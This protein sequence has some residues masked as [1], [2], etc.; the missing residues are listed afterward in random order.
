MKNKY[1]GE[2]EKSAHIVIYGAG[3]IGRKV[4]G[5][6]EKMNMQNKVVCFAVSDQQDAPD[7]IN[8]IMV[9]SIDVAARE[10]GDALFLLSVSERFMYELEQRVIHEKIDYYFDGKKIYQKNCQSDQEQKH[11][12]IDVNELFMQQYRNGRYNRMDIVVRYLAIENYHGIND[13]GFDLYCRMQARRMSEDYVNIAVNRFQELIVSWERD[14]Y[15]EGSEIECDRNLHL[16][17][18]SHRIAMGLYYGLEKL[19]CKIDSYEDDIEY[20]LDWFIE[21]GF[22]QNEIRLIA[23]KFDQ[24]YRTA[25]RTISCVLWPSVYEYY[26]EITEKLELLFTIKSVKDYYFRGETFE[27]AVRGIYYIDDIDS[28]KIDKKIE[29]LKVYPEKTIRVIEL[30]ISK[31]RFRLKANGH[32]ILTEGERI[33]RIFRNCYK[34]RIDDYF[35]DIIMHTGDNYEQSKYILELFRQEFSLRD[36]FE[37]IIQYNWIV[38]KTDSPTTPDDFPQSYPFSKDIDIICLD[39]DYDAIVHSTERF[40]KKRLGEMRRINVIAGRGNTRFRVE[41]KGYLIFQFDISKQLPQMETGFIRHSIEQRVCK[42][43]Y[44]VAKKQHELIYRIYECLMYP[45]KNWHYAYIEENKALFDYG[46]TVK[47]LPALN[48][49]S[50]EVLTG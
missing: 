16:I 46:E 3:Q 12:D 2:V 14:G 42:E 29:Y 18:G 7:T 21:H 34:E 6:L 4:Y 26:G 43:G 5:T 24:L 30:D 15:R 23:E 19:S 49:M 45:A 25:C 27:K 9:K 36:Y 39:E 35:Y 28:W 11:I 40:L 47:A 48:I 1:I 31:P 8:G 38:I 10:Y 17:D 33:K 37:E 22:E 13:Y 32:T 41:Q 20:G 50:L 44:Y